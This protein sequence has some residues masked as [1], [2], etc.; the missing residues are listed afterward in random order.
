MKIYFKLKLK[1]NSGLKENRYIFMGNV[2]F[3][4]YI[5][6]SYRSVFFE[7]DRMIQDDIAP[8]YLELPK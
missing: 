1:E 5:H 4:N 8:Y 6:G 3:F 2:L 7:T